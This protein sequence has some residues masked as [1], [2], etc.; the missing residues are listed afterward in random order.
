M[1]MF[2]NFKNSS[3]FATFYAENRFTQIV[4]CG[5]FFIANCLYANIQGYQISVDYCNHLRVIVL[6]GT[7]GDSLSYFLLT[8]NFH[9]QMPRTMKIANFV[10]NSNDVCTYSSTRT[11]P[12]GFKPQTHQSQQITNVSSAKEYKKHTSFADV[13]AELE[14]H[15]TIEKNAKNKAYDF[16]LQMGLL[17]EFQ[18]FCFATQGQNHFANCLTSLTQM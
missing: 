10:N 11:A 18:E 17:D 1:K 13:L 9:S 6:G 14:S 12:I 3:M 15:F 2:V 5:I 7:R 16:I 8:N 4:M